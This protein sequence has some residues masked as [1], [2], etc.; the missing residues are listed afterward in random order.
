MQ[1]SMKYL[2]A[3][4]EISLAGTLGIG[5]ST[6]LMKRALFLP[7][8]FAL[9]GYLRRVDKKDFTFLMKLLPLIA[10]SLGMV[11]C[12]ITEKDRRGHTRLIIA[13]SAQPP[14]TNDWIE[15]L[16]KIRYQT[17][18]FSPRSRVQPQSLSSALFL[19]R[20]NH[21]PQSSF[22]SPIH[23]ICSDLASARHRISGFLGQRPHRCPLGRCRRGCRTSCRPVT[24]CR[25]SSFRFQRRRICRGFHPK[26][27]ICISNTSP[28]R[29]RKG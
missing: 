14:S 24:G 23:S 9:G 3:S 22:F 8:R 26:V 1:F 19:P 18:R 7:F 10:Q 5:K 17:K 28:L 29:L 20:S 27:S 6:P 13:E 11:L 4:S 12:L 21:T 15:T 16:P 25:R 2:E